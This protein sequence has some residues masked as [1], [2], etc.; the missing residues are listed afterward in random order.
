MGS[1]GVGA[2]LSCDRTDCVSV[3]CNVESR[4]AC[5]DKGS[6]H[7]CTMDKNNEGIT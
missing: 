4:L 7:F 3:Q 2:T 5:D 1:R 6:G